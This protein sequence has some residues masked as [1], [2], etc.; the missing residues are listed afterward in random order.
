MT[1]MKLPGLIDVHVH[2][3]EPGGTHKED[4]DSGTVAAL[5][6]GFTTVLAMPNTRPPITDA[7]TLAASLDAARAKARCD[8]GQYLGAGPDNVET[9]AGACAAR[10]RPEDVPRPDLRPA[11][12]GRDDAVDG[13]FRGLAQEFAHRRPRREP[14][15][16]RGDPDG[17][18]LRPARAPGARLAARG[19]PADPRGQ[20]A[21]AEGD[22]RGRAAPPLPQRRRHPGAGRRAAARCAR[23]WRPPPTGRRFGTTWR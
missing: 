20:G 18:A 14:H 12:A 19:D 7:A 17:R 15:A 16:G 13:A 11:A 8:Y 10:R 6:G 9:A 5:A 3:R 1:L 4:W 23:G 2:M 22:L 21:R